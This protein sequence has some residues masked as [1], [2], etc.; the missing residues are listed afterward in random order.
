M[1]ENEIL[2]VYGKI[3]NALKFFDD[4]ISKTTDEEE[5]DDLLKFRGL[6]K[7]TIKDIL[8]YCMSVFIRLSNDKINCDKGQVNEY[9]EKEN[10]RRIYHNALIS[11]IKLADNICKKYEIEPIFGKFGSFEKDTSPLFARD[12]T[13]EASLKRKEIAVWALY[14]VTYALTKSTSL[15]KGFINKETKAS[16]ELDEIYKCISI[17]DMTNMFN[18]KIRSM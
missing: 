9:G 14:I 17:N 6:I 18:D 16:D 7:E 11:S 3:N 12:F 10:R 5:K 15:T 8:D 1:S 4:K 2:E 13:A